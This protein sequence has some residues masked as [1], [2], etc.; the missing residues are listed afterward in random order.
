MITAIGRAKEP[1]REAV[2]DAL[3]SLGEY[4]GVLGTWHFDENGDISLSNISGLQVQ[5]DTWVFVKALK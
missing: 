1:T 4:N 3:L 2:L 5:N